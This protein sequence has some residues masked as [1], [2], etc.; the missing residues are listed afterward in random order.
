[1]S[2][3]V[4]A[5]KWRPK[6]FAELVGQEHVVRALESGLSSGR[7]HHAFLFTGT[8]GVGKTTIARIIAKAL[9]CETGVSATPCGVCSACT[10]IDQGRYVDLMEIDAA[11]RTKVDD[12]RELLDSVVYAPARGRYKVYLIDEV[13]MLST[14]SFN[15]LLKTLEEPPPHVKFLLAT[16]DPQK[17]PVTVLSRCLKFHLKRMSVA[18]VQSQM[19][20]ILDAE[21]ISYEPEALHEL[22]RGA[23]GSM[24]DGLSLL[25]QAIGYGG[26]RVDALATR[27]MLGS[28]ARD[29]LLDLLLAITAGDSA[30]TWT[31]LSA[32]VAH[33]PNYLT[34]CGQLQ[35]LLHDAALQQTLGAQAGLL[36]LPQKVLEL[37]ARTQPSELQLLYQICLLAAR[38]LGL[39]PDPRIAFEM[40]VLRLLS[41]APAAQDDAG[42]GGSSG[43][44]TG[45]NA[46]GGARASGSLAGTGAVSASAASAARSAAAQPRAATASTTLATPPVPTGA[47]SAHFTVHATPVAA[48]VAVAAP[49]REAALSST[50]A[51]LSAAPVSATAPE[52]AALLAY[53]ELVERL[54]LAGPL[55]QLALQ[56]C[57]RAC[58]AGRLDLLLPRD[59]AYLLS[60]HNRSQLLALINALEPSLEV[61]IEAGEK[62]GPTLAEQAAQR[63]DAQR[64]S[65]IA[66]LDQDP[67]VR[68]LRSQFDARILSDSVQTTP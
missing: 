6:N 44:A 56:C 11:S 32:I 59:W 7:L 64:Q 1:M 41:F 47:S 30:A 40:A 25:D 62:C 34:V 29:S 68:A 38:D 2:Y 10:D 48:A 33:N 67:L 49:T 65:F 8:R 31:Q 52:P 63:A 39:A 5:R 19:Q 22:A 51:P 17:L 50:T 53:G 15:A 21:Q 14:S 61:R 4:L 23:D 27:E 20:R 3:L 9:N 54:N 57:V 35:E 43:G 26:G 42:G 55:K 37:A 46:S 16:T 13:H 58:A 24:R 60:E 18:Q 66:E 28:V 45:G 12:T 36:E